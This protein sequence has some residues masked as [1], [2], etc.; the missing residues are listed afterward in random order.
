MASITFAGKPVNTSGTLPQPGAAAPAFSL[1][2]TDLTEKSLADFVG[3]TVVLNIFPSLDTSVCAMSVRKFN[4][5]AAGL[6]NTVVLSV[7]RDLPFAIKRFCALEGIA[8]V[9]GLSELRSLAFGAD[10]GVEILDGPLRG[11][12]ARAVVVIDSNGVVRHSELVG[13]ITTEPDYTAAL[14]AAKS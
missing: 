3:K 12:L 7:S 13:E 9:Q 11:L 4:E 2:A 10:Y 14:S 5:L 1:T 6:P 8:N